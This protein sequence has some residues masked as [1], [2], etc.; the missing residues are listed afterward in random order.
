MQP[1]WPRLTSFRH[2]ALPAL[3][4]G[5]T[6]D[7]APWSELAAGI[8]G[9]RVPRASAVML[10]M[11]PPRRDESPARLVFIRRS[12]TVRSHRGQISF[13]GGRADPEDATPGVTATRELEE[14]LGV[15]SNRVTVIGTMAP[16]AALDGGAVVPVLGITDFALEEMRPSVAEVQDVFAGAWPNF[17]RSKNQPFGFNIFGNWR[18]S[19]RFVLTDHEPHRSIWGLTAMI[20][21]AADFR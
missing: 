2:G 7:S 15:P 19:P 8:A 11:I 18:E 13:P 5:L 9:G 3:V 4:H 20:L 1:Q 17:A 12:T 10:L 16:I 14:E 6:A 21:A